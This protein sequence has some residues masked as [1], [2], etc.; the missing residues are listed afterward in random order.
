MGISFYIINDDETTTRNLC[1]LINEYNEFT[2]LGITENYEQGMNSILK[3][4]P[5]VLFINLDSYSGD[6]FSFCQEVKD[7]L[8]NHSKFIALSKDT[9]SSYLAL[10]NKFYDYIL[11]PGKELE[12]RKIILQLIK[13]KEYGLNEVLC[14][15]SYKDYTILQIEEILFLKADNNATDFIMTNGKNI[16]AFKTLKFF[17]GVL[18]SSFIRIHNSYIINKNHLSRINFGKLKCFLDHSNISLPFSRSY[19]HNL[20][21]LEELLKHKAISFN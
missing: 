6:V 10:K 12:I 13:S 21:S 7:Y 14:L 16:S 9:S 15:K 8:L 11:K 20:Q 17:E 5:D 2:C 4:N 19:R 3:L 1:D 18:P